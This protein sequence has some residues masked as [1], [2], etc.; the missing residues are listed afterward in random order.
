[1]LRN[2]CKLLLGSVVGL[3]RGFPHICCY[4]GKRTIKRTLPTLVAALSLF[5]SLLTTG[6][7]SSGLRNDL[8]CVEWGVKLYSLTHSSGDPLAPP[9]LSLRGQGLRALSGPPSGGR[10]REGAFPPLAVP[11]ADDGGV[12]CVTFVDELSDPR[13]V[14][15][16]DVAWGRDG[17]PLTL[18]WDRVS[19]PADT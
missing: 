11:V 15:P 10:M 12:T 16:S 14:L 7:V 5:L 4:Y 6:W 2:M 13:C 9:A 19:I 17:G 3:M 8:Y 18:A 1:M